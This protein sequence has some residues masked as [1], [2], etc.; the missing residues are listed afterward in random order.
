MD[1]IYEVVQAG[2]LP[3]RPPPEAGQQGRSQDFVV[4][5]GCRFSSL[6]VEIGFVDDLLGL[7]QVIGVGDLEVA[8][9]DGN[10]AH[11]LGVTI[12]AAVQVRW[13]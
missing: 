9:R 5:G 4:H 2:L 3:I 11:E 6:K 7:E 10:A 8:M 12:G 1:Q 13:R